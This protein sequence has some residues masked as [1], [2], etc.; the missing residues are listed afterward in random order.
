MKLDET[1]L[2]CG[3]QPPSVSA[4]RIQVGAFQPRSLVAGPG[5]RAVLWVAGC[6]RRCPQCMKP[7]LFSFEAGQSI[8]VDILAERILAIPGLGGV[9]YSGGEPFEQAA[10][11]GALSRKLRANGLSIL[12]YSGYRL[13]AL[14]EEPA[15]FE[16]L[17]QETDI[18]IDGEYRH[19]LP[20]PTRWRGSMNQNVHVLSARG[21][22]DERI[23]DPV[24]EIQVSL[25]DSG[26]RISGF[27]SPSVEHELAAE[28]ATRG[29]ILSATRGAESFP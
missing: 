17:L 23:S 9:T 6:N 16:P 8:S 11:L 24:R 19:E 4:D 12:V 28:L 18:L 5:E 13:Q 26:V 15:R 21:E 2:I 7:E 25:T 29:I 20:G 27:T 10:A 14:K 3:A 1:F 22:H